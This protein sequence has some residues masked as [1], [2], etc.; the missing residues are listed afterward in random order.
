MKIKSFEGIGTRRFDN[1]SPI[2]KKPK[3]KQKSDL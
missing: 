1:M 3:D 2:Y